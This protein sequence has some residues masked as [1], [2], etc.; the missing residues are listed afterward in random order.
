M[1]KLVFLGCV[2]GAPSARHFTSS[3]ALIYNS[4][5]YLFDCC[6]GATK[7]LRAAGLSLHKIRAVFISH[8]HGDH[9]LGLPGLIMSMALLNRTSP[10]RIYGPPGTT[11]FVQHLLLSGYFELTFRLEIVELPLERARIHEEKEFWVE[12]FPVQHGIPALGYIFREKPKFRI[13]LEKA[14]LLGLEPGPL[15]GKLKAGEAVQVNGRIVLP[16]EVLEDTRSD[17]SLLYSGDTLPLDYGYPFDVVVHEATFT[18]RHADLAKER[19]HSTAAEVAQIARKNSVQLLV[20]THFS[21]RYEESNFREILEE[22]KKYFE[23]TVLAEDLLVLELKKRFGKLEWSVHRP[24]S[25][26]PLV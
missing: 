2:S 9:Y 8:F 19:F 11:S 23:P 4:R 13:S 1:L 25:L 6:E 24:G 20:L 26:V 15:L 3:M 7:Q 16:E 17:I 12:A 18:S 14:R 22:A 5:I 21:Q 10:L